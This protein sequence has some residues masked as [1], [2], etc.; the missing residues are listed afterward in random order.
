MKFIKQ[1]INIVSHNDL[2]SRL[3]KC[4][5]DSLSGSAK[6]FR[7]LLLIHTKFLI[8]VFYFLNIRRFG[9]FQLWLLGL[10]GAHALVFETATQLYSEGVI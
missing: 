7:F 9:H 2:K 8:I 6:L 10:L 1:P 5:Y 3:S 4:Q